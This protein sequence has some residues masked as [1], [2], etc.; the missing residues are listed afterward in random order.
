MLRLLTAAR[1]LE[2][3]TG[4]AGFAVGNGN[5]SGTTP[6]AGGIIITLATSTRGSPRRPPRSRSATYTR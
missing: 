6:Q 4:P 3:A 1:D 5:N 2:E